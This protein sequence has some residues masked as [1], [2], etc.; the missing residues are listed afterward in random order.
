MTTDTHADSERNQPLGLAST[1]LLGRLDDHARM[2]EELVQYSGAEQ[3]QWAADLR[4][5]AQ[6]LVYLRARSG[7]HAESSAIYARL[8]SA[9]RAGADD[10]T[11]GRLLRA[12]VG[13]RA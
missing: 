2:H 9:V 3:A 13:A 6:E 4:A 5:A 1:A 10:A 12:E 8:A 11:L 7:I